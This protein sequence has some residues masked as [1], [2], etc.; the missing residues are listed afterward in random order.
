MATQVVFRNAAFAEL[1][2]LARHGDL[3][4]VYSAR[5]ETQNQAVVLKQ[6]IEK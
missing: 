1:K 5:D 6:L 3:T 4:L 2:A